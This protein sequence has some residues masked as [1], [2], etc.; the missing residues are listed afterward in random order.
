MEH[1]TEPSRQVFDFIVQKMKAG[2]WKPDE[3]IWVEDEFVKNLGVSKSTV[4]KAIDEL[5]MCGLVKKIQGSGT[6][7]QP[8]DFTSG[9]RY[10]FPFTPKMDSHDLNMMLG[11]RKYFEYGNVRLFAENHTQNDMKILEES[12]SR[13]KDS[14]NDLKAFANADY[15]FH[16]QIAKGTQNEFIIKIFDILSDI[17]QSYLFYQA[18]SLGLDNGLE[19]HKLILRWLK[20]EDYELAAQMMLKH[21]EL[22]KVTNEEIM[23]DPSDTSK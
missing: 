8:F 17:M 2:E 23:I 14:V 5:Q 15:D 13:M 7:V 21:I 18:N 10:V 20:E 11:F 6:Y 3:K 19:Y 1:T 16:Y 22:A 4:R 12:Y 9:V